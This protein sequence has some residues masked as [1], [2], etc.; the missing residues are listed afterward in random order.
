MRKIQKIFAGMA[1]GCAMALAMPAFASA[2]CFVNEGN[3]AG[4]PES[5]GASRM[6]YVEFHPS[7]MKNQESMVSR[8]K[9]GLAELPFARTKGR[10]M[11]GLEPYAAPLAVAG[12]PLLERVFVLYVKPGEDVAAVVERLKEN[13]AV[14]NVEIAP[15][16]RFHAADLISWNAAT[17]VSDARTNSG[18]KSEEASADPYDGDYLGLD[19]NWHLDLIHAKEALALQ[20]VS[21]EVT[22]A[23]VDNAVWGEHPDLQIPKENQYNTATGE[24]T[25]SP[26]DMGLGIEQHEICD[27][28]D[29]DYGMCPSYNW[30][31][32]TH[33][34][35][36]LGAVS[37]NGEGVAS[38]AS[39]VDML[40]VAVPSM[41]TTEI[42]GNPYEGIRW[43]VEHGAKVVNCS[44]S[45]VVMSDYER[46][47]VET[48]VDQGIIIV[49]SAGDRG[50]YEDLNYPAAL[51]GVISVGAC[52]YDK[53]LADGSNYG[54][55]VDVLAPGGEGPTSK[56]NV[57]S[58]MFGQAQVLP[59]AGY[60]TFEGQYYDYMRG[61]S[62]ATPLVSALC[63]LVL[64]KDSTVTPYEMEELL[65]ATAQK[66]YNLGISA[67]SGIIDAKAAVEAVDSR[68]KRVYADYIT[69]FS[70]VCESSIAKLYWEVDTT[71]SDKPDFLRF[72]RDG[73]LCADSLP[74]AGGSYK[75]AEAAVSSNHK[76]EI[77]GVQDG[78][79]SFR[80]QAFVSVGDYYQLQAVAQPE[81]GGRIYGAGKY[82]PRSKA[83]L[84]AEPNPGYRFV[85]WTYYDLWE[86]DAY[87]EPLLIVD[88]RQEYFGVVAHFEREDVAVESDSENQG[89]DVWPNPV[90]G[91]LNWALPAGVQW[92]RLD[93]MDISGRKI[94]SFETMPCSQDVAF[95]APGLYVLRAYSVD[96]DVLT[97]KFVKR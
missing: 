13:P 72:Y 54:G 8:Y 42:Q 40:A 46:E 18:V 31:H 21:P 44:W 61:T 2:S 58:T 89:F 7:T 55:W 38:L 27:Q 11:E 71:V 20:P 49:A 1:T 81:E 96:G 69:Y 59:N 64:S 16:Y 52:N 82:A 29:M 70:G 15:E 37:G 67:N 30:S 41:S 10:G 57:F 76:Y 95:L 62:I 63:A 5:A 79:E 24:M 34:A 93:L 68:V 87:K 83:R 19:L 23:V 80:V 85:K 97:A 92:E 39:G 26:L 45:A 25:S 94:A 35:G 47:L 28:G 14:K 51:P 88:M 73:F 60:E 6:L 75:D 22:V 48:Y 33:V 91:S 74:F 65:I 36:L 66:G 77:C 53:T 50:Q 4:R 12:N 56:E 9:V 90:S 32:G 43:A 3:V 17:E 84:I 78:V 86:G